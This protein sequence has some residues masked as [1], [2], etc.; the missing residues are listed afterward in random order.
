M[1]GQPSC[2]PMLVPLTDLFL[3]KLW[4]PLGA[5]GSR[6]ATLSQNFIWIIVFLVGAVGVVND[7]L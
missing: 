4:Y 5:R 3:H 6:C 1:R 2:W 7:Y